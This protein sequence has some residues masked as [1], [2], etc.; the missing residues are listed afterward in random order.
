[1]I[2]ALQHISTQ[3]LLDVDIPDDWKYVNSDEN[4][5]QKSL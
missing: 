1:M 3:A 5:N 2:R 4:R